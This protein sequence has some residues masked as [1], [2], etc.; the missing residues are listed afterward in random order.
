[1]LGTALAPRL[2]AK[3]EVVLTDLA[4]MDVTDHDATA[5]FV[6]GIRPDAIIHAAAM[7]QVD[8]CEAGWE[9]AHLVNGIGSRNVALAAERVNARILYVSTDFVFDGAKGEPYMEHD[10]VR[11]LSVYGASKLAGE[12]AVRGLT[13]RHFVVR[14]AWLYGAGGPNFV[15]TILRAADQGRALRVVTDQVGS[16]TWTED[17][18][19]GIASLV[20]TELYGV[21]HLTNA[22]ACSW[23]EYAC[24][25]LRLAGRGEVEVAR[26]TSAEWA[27][28]AAR[29]AYSVLRNF[30]WVASGFA[31]LRPWP[32]ALAEYLRRREGGPR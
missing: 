27:A 24:T 25:I 28:P 18:A 11:P 14:T 23:H 19:A 16:P 9:K 31:P 8:A 6:A 1:M 7:T 3:H 15:E 22:G 12:E 5:E 30:A 20:E 29:P 21:Y 4:E 13:R 17:L 32:E 2:A 10:A 26:T